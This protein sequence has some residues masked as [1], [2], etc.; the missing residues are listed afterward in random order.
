MLW[1]RF[2]APKR[3]LDL[4]KSIEKQLYTQFKEKGGAP[5]TDYPIYFV[6]GRPKWAIA[7]S[8]AESM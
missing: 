7:T 2:G 3:Y 5:K 8:E 1:Q 4:R 6:V